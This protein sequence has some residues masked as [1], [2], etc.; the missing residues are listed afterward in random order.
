MASPKLEVFVVFDS[1]GNPLPGIL[2]S[3]SFS[4]YKND[5]GTD[6]VPQPTLIEVGGGAYGFIP[7]FAD[8]ARGIV[9]VV[10]A[11]AT[12][13]PQFIWRYMRPEDWNADLI[14]RLQAFAEGHWKIF[15]TGPDAFRLVLYDKN[16]TTAIQKWDLK[17]FTGNPS[18]GP[19]IAE[20]I[21]VLDIP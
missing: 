20:R 8:Q 1:S 6:I 19:S 17:D 7:T 13:S 16:G 5:Q 12:A 21:P 9:Y 11:G 4:S 18:V 15:T 2:G 3:M 14:T 10:N